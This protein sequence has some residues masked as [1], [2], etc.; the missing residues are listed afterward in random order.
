MNGTSEPEEA[1]LDWRTRVNNPSETVK[2]LER[3]STVDLS[4]LAVGFVECTAFC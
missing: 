3:E 4:A 1:V 2:L